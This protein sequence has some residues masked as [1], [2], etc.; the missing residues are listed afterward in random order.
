MSCMPW[1]R[2]WRYKSAMRGAG[3]AH[4]ARHIRRTDWSVVHRHIRRAD[5]LGVK[6]R[7]EIR[8][9]DVHRVRRLPRRVRGYPLRPNRHAVGAG[10][11]VERRDESGHSHCLGDHRCADAARRPRGHQDRPRDRSRRRAAGSPRDGDS[12][13]RSQIAIHGNNV[14]RVAH[15]AQRDRGIHGSSRER[16]RRA[17]QRA[18]GKVSGA[19]ASERTSSRSSHRCWTS[20]G[21]KLDATPSSWSARTSASYCTRPSLV[22]P[23]AD[24][25]HSSVDGHSERSVLRDGRRKVRQ[26]VLNLLSNAQIHRQGRSH[27]P[28]H[29]RASGLRIEVVDTESALSRKPAHFDPFGRRTAAGRERRVARARTGH[30]RSLHAFAR[31]IAS[32][33]KR[34]GPRDDVRG[35]DSAGPWPGTSTRAPRCAHRARLLWNSRT[36]EAPLARHPEERSDKDRRQGC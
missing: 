17:D 22:L 29:D 23:A 26:I 2:R 24:Q 3:V 31:R 34:A 10:V 13:E 15:A 32:G 19:V 16:N 14:A 30:R 25:K 5:L 6:A 20:S 35:V 33:G 21:S 1:R 18:A 9:G 7:R 36:R 11:L 27:A 12:S 8:S 28:R 4:V